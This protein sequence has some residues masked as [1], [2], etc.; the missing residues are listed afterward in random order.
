[1]KQSRTA[2]V[3]RSKRPASRASIPVVLDMHGKIVLESVIPD[4]LPV[5][6]RFQGI[7]D[8]AAASHS[9]PPTKPA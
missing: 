6:L 3:P 2:R 7:D 9:L 1:M 8:K 4:A 5:L